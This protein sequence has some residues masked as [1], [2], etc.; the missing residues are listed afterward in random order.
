MAETITAWLLFGVIKK[1]NRWKNKSSAQLFGDRDLDSIFLFHLST[2]QFW[3]HNPI[4]I[5]PFHVPLSLVIS[6]PLSAL[7][8]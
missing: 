6:P 5:I 7:M 8:H 2:H 4:Q 1:A 3:G